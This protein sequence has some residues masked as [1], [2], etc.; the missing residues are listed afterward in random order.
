M[1]NIGV[2]T[3]PSNDKSFARPVTRFLSI[4]EPTAERIFLFGGGIVIRESPLPHQQNVD[5]GDG[6][7][8]GIS[9]IDYGLLQLYI[10]IKIF[11][12]RRQLDL[13]YLHKGAM[14]L[15]LPVTIARL[16]GIRTCVIKIGAFH[17]ERT[18]EP[19]LVSKLVTFAQFGTF[20]AAHG[21]VVFTETE[22]PSV[23]NQNVFVAFSNY[24]D[25]DKFDIS[26][27]NNKRPINM[28]FVGR[29][30]EVKGVVEVAKA[31]IIL[32]NTNPDYQVR[33]VGEGPEFALVERLVSDYDRITLTGWVNHDTIAE[34]YNKMKVLVAPSKA[35]GLPTG[36]VEALGCGVVVAATPVGS[37]SDLIRDG[38][39]GFLLSNTNPESIAECV[40]YIN[41]RDDLSDIGRNARDH[42]V[43]N[44]S[45]SAVTSAFES[46]TESMTSK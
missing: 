28:G 22:I 34:E 4:L 6:S 16:L 38:E 21:V 29:F 30:S 19:S 46:I 36:L 14:G 2:I 15:I 18:G 33:L 11:Q 9:F 7:F 43:E 17:N 31:A 41:N 26:C 27:P 39:T 44:Y 8:L 20:R 1:S 32:V 25:F 12:H 3:T 13:L 5:I 42:V 24:R 40:K 45:K 10:C 37:I 23:P 35:E